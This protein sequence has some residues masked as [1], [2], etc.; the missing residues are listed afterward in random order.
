MCITPRLI[1]FLI[2]QTQFNS[3]CARDKKQGTKNCIY[4]PVYFEKLDLITISLQ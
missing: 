1:L 2:Q 3:K 4:D